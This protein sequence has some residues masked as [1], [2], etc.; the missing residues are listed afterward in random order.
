MRFILLLAA[1]SIF[2][3]G[4]KKDKAG[5][6]ASITALSC[7][8]GSFSAQATAGTAYSATATVPYSGGNGVSFV[9]GSAIAST[10]VTGLTATLQ[11][12]TLT[13][14]SGNITYSVAGTPQTAGTASFAISFGGQSCTLN[15]TV[16]PAGGLAVPPVYNKI[17]GAT[18]ITF[19]G[20]YVT[21]K[22]SDQP[23]HKSCY[24][25]TTNPLYEEIGRAHV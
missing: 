12:G 18:S 25:Q 5:N 20:T 9:V 11:A 16:N 2:G 19:D 14:G 15:L 1:V 17:Y 13:S 4:C 21:I 7:S 8:G 10:G 23:D 3:I 6:A 24:Y 22:S